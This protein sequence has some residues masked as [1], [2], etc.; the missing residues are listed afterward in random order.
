MEL[1][2]NFYQGQAMDTRIEV[3]SSD[4]FECNS[5]AA[6]QTH[7]EANLATTEWTGAIVEEFYFP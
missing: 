7:E 3:L 4:V 5:V 2:L 6:V 1:A